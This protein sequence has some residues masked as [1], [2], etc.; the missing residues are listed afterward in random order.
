[1]TGPAPTPY[2]GVENLEV[3]REAENYNRYLQS[4]VERH[5][6][7]A[8][9]VIDFGAAHSDLTG[10]SMSATAGMCAADSVIRAPAPRNAPR[11]RPSEP[12]SNN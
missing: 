2:T 5:A 7:G 11:R 12:S 3:M 6:A 4:L 10:G 1:M 8:K 9:R